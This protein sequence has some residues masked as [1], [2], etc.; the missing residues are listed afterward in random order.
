MTEKILLVDDDPN[1]LAAYTRV[2]RNRFQFETALGGAEGLRMASESGP[3][4]VIVS[5]LRMPGMDGIEFLAR[6]REKSPDTVRM[7]LTGNVDVKAAVEAVN[8]GW[9]FR[10]LTKPCLPDDFSRALQAGIDQYRLILSER[11]LLQSTLNGSIRV[12]TEILSIADPES[13]GK[14]NRLRELIQTLALALKIADPWELEL[15]AMLA[16]IGH[17]T[18]PPSVLIKQRAG[19]PLSEIEKDMIARAPQTGHN[20]LANIPRLKSVANIVLYQNKR[21]NGDGFPK[22]QI[23]GDR[24]PAGARMLKVLID[25][26]VAET[27]GMTRANAL[28]EMK[29]RDG[30]YDPAILDSAY[31]CFA[32]ALKK[33]GHVHRRDYFIPA[34]NLKVGQILL[35]DVLTDNGT[36]LIK[37]GNWIS[38]TIL[39]RINNFSKLNGVQEPIHVE[40]LCDSSEGIPAAPERRAG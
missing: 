1:I 7:L 3:Y 29:K 22:N 11:E 40:V 21:Y 25:M 27:E 39:E 26:T 9:I 18:I 14:G 33:T 28:E 16:Q 38:D 31:L 4:S 23:A 2:L 36:L 17:V 15:A 10:F 20:L 32:P 30:W 19:E 13:F 37:A 5:D 35:S 24:I 8:Q 34:R 12:L 6:S